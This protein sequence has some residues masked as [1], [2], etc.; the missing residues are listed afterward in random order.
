MLLDK[1]TLKLVVLQALQASSYAALNQ[2]EHKIQPVIEPNCQGAI[3]T[4]SA[5][6]LGDFHATKPVSVCEPRFALTRDYYSPGYR[7]GTDG[8]IESE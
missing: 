5:V 3:N 1:N 7:V 2:R 4:P 8:C 6:I